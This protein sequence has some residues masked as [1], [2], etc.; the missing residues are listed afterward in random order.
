[1]EPVRPPRKIDTPAPS[2]ISNI[3]TVSKVGPFSYQTSCSYLLVLGTNELEIRIKIKYVKWC[4]GCNDI[5]INIA[6]LH[7]LSTFDYR[8]L[9][10]IDIHLLL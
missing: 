6:R 7:T 4:N 8:Y 2:R 10:I 1:M 9:E 5:D 3:T